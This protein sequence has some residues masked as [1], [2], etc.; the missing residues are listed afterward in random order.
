ML[1]LKILSIVFSEAIAYALEY[2]CFLL[3]LAKGQ[4]VLP[5]SGV[6]GAMYSLVVIQTSEILLIT[7]NCTNFYLIVALDIVTWYDVPWA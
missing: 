3:K 1:K 7:T 2:E 5:G 6:W 4:D